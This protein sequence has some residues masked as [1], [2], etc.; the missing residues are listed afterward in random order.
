MQNSYCEPGGLDLNMP[1]HSVRGLVYCLFATAKPLTSTASLWSSH[2][3]AS[4]CVG[5]NAP[6]A[7]PYPSWP[8]P[9]SWALKKMA[10]TTPLSCPVG[11][12]TH[13]NRPIP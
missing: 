8:P 6:N 2:N 3:K 5:K 9:R 11:N 13:R 4:R 7:R 10:L 1:I 12:L